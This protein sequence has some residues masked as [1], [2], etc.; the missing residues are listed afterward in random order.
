LAT[1]D[2]PSVRVD[3]ERM[4]NI[5]KRTIILFCFI[6]IAFSSIA[7]GESTFYY[8]ANEGGSI[9]KID[10][11]SNKLVKNIKI[12]GVVHNVQISPTGANLG[13][14][15]I[16]KMTSDAKEMDMKGVALFFNTENDQLIKKINVGTHP[17][18]I[19]YSSDGKYVLVTNNE[20]NT[21]SVIDSKTYGIVKTIPTGKG[22]HGFRISKDSNYAY[23]AN[24]GED[25]VSVINL[26]ALKE[27]R[28][29]KVGK[30]PVTTGI[31]SDG[32]TLVVTLNAENSLA[33][34]DLATDKVEKIQVG[35]GPAQVFIEPDDK[36][37]FVANQGT[38]KKPSNTVSKIDLKIKNVVATIVV[39]KGAHGVVTS[40]DGKFIYV[41]NMF[42]NTVSVIDNGTN[43]VIATVPVAQTPNGITYKY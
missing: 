5:M 4:K 9:S 22:P 20:D 10:G 35:Y 27:E 14:V 26:I 3:S 16:P 37:V 19:V 24:M 41:T 21:V 1:G 29:I 38:E 15:S 23:V 7:F 6:S 32:K 2:R 39:G 8:T 43:V 40:N 31:T 13:A 18:H 28:K 42:E 36:Y 11:L 34:V 25:T 33:L 12:D 17:A 30:T